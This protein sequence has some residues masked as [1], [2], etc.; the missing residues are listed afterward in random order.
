[1]IGPRGLNFELFPQNGKT[2]VLLN[3]MTQ[4]TLHWRSQ[5]R[6]MQDFFQILTYDARGQGGTAVGEEP[7]S[8]ELH[9]E[10]LAVLLDS[11]GIE[12]VYLVGFSH[13]AR[14][15]LKFATMYP[16][17]TGGL[18][19]CSATARPTALARTIIR[20]WSEVLKAGGLEAM[21]WSSL[22]TILGQKFLG[23]NEHLLGGIIKASLQRNSVEGVSKLLEGM[24]DYPDLSDLARHVSCHCLVISADEDLLVTREGAEELARLAHGQHVEIE[25]CGHTIPIE[26]PDEFRNA[27]LSF[28]QSLN[29][30]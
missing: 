11:L 22:P 5:A 14:V 23:E 29:R 2:V 17:R 30:S 21:S 16:Q 15:A 1:M 28:L 4:S 13:G 9:A 18:V 7:L 12:D 27:V 25:G 24:R 19:L 8:L 6:A 26:A 3:G 10:D 20:S